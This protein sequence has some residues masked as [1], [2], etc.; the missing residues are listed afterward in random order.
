MQMQLA[1]FQVGHLAKCVEFPTSF[2]FAWQLH[3]RTLVAI[4][5]KA[6]PVC[7][8]TPSAGSLETPGTIAEVSKY[9][10]LLRK[11]RIS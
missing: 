4:G 1:G 5:A 8:G 2:L 9:L 3:R 10:A 11:S 6:R 7:L